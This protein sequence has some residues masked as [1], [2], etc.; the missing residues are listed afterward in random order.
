MNAGG[1]M[2]PLTSAL[3]L[4]CRATLLRCPAFASHEALLAVFVIAELRPFASRLPEAGNCEARVDQTLAFLVD[5]QLGDGRDALPLFIAAL[6]D[7]TDRGDALWSELDALLRLLT[8][9]EPSPSAQANGSHH[10][11]NG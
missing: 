2:R 4:R 6:R 1:V 7:R 5:K 9:P 3:Y 11:I 8:T 10:D